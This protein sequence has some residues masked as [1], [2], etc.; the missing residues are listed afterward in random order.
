MIMGGQR[1]DKLGMTFFW[2]KKKK[3][4][5]YIYF[6]RIIRKIKINSWIK[7]EPEPKFKKHMHI[8]AHKKKKSI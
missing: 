6:M 7:I 1:K 5:P 8:F 4:V 2:L 3:Y